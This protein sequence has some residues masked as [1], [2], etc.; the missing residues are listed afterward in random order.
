MSTFD[1]NSALQKAV[2][3]QRSG[4]VAEAAAIYRQLVR[5]APPN[6]QVLFFLGAAEMQLGNHNEA[7]RALRRSHE[8][9]PDQPRT[10]CNLGLALI[11]LKRNEEAVTSFDRALALDPR[12]ALAHNNRGAALLELERYEEALASF[13]SAVAVEP[14]YAEA[15]NNRGTALRLLARNE[16][17][18][19]SFSRA[20]A[21]APGY[22]VAHHNRG[23]ALL[24]LCRWDEALASF[25]RALALDR[26]N[27]R[28]HCGRATALY[29][30]K[31]LDEARNDN[32]RALTIDPALPEARWNKARLALIAGDF[33]TGLEFYESRWQTPGFSDDRRDYP[34]PL[35]DGSQPIAGKTLFVHDEQGFGDAIQC[36]RYLPLARE[37][38]AEVIL[39]ARQRLLPLLASLKGGIRLMAK[40]APPPAF[41]LYCPIMS[42]PRAF[43][44]AFETIPAQIPYLF[45]E[46]AKREVLRARLGA[47]TVPRIGVAWSGS[48]KPNVDRL[49][50]L[51]LQ[52]L[53]PLASGPFEF[54]SLQKEN[55][56]DEVGQLERL[57]QLQRHEDEQN[58]FSD[59]AALIDCM[60]L[61]VTVD[62]VV[63]HIAGAMGK[64]V[65]ILLPFM[66]DWRWRA[67]GSDSPWYPTA[68]LFRQKTM[69]DWSAV[70][71]EVSARLRAHFGW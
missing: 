54:H 28:A 67:E 20:A 40:G 55:R 17:A 24:D 8:L 68:T 6:A 34:R 41:D 39:E 13:E 19:A 44:T 14:G 26:S 21:I 9:A 70:I 1:F 48:P 56:P 69:G 64:P 51:P 45:A 4:R 50:R 36:C 7:V 18:L 5:G 10:L 22:A 38:G 2:M 11:N 71:A 29:S 61:V 57:P 43:H 42:L 32:E 65:W 12:Y 27:A 46:A 62:T 66:P 31:R 60:D 25:D 23:T 37:A 53:A 30:L 16:E 15:H 52:L 33:A 59:A 63:A 3:L 49:R 58:D 35:W 47:K